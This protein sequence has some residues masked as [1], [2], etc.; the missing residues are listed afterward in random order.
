MAAR[1]GQQD[2][3]AESWSATRYDLQ[4]RLRLMNE[5]QEAED[6]LQ[7]T[8]IDAFRALDRFEGRSRLSTWLYRIAYNAALMRL[9]KRR[10]ATVSLD[11]P[12]ETEDGELL[13]RQLVDWTALPDELLLSK[14]FAAYWLQRWRLCRSHCAACLCCGILRGCPRLR[15]PRLWV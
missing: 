13:P 6:V 12:W 1:A 14:E 11:E 2:A 5:P 3:F 10:V 8:F 7:E 15:R 4:S 9:R